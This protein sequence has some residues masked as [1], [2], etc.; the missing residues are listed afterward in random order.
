V[1]TVFEIDAL[2]KILKLVRHMVANGYGGDV[3]KVE[4]DDPI[5]TVWGDDGKFRKFKITVKEV[6]R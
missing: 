5:V 3:D 4:L 6:K 1:K 2:K